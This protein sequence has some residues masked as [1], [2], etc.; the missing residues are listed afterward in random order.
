[1]PLLP[2]RTLPMTKITAPFL[3]AVMASAAS[4]EQTFEQAAVITALWGSAWPY[5]FVAALIV[6]DV[7]LGVWWLTSERK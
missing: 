7:G 2:R 6:A 3:L 4:A 5:A 1:M